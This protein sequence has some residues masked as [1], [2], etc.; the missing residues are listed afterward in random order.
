MKPVAFEY[1][2]PGKISEAAE[3]LARSTGAKILAGGQSLGPLLNLRLAR[4]EV[5][6]DI[7]RIG[8]LR[9]IEETDTVWRVGAGVTH[10]QLEDVGDRLVGAELL[11][12]VARGIAYR[13]VRNRGTIGGSVAHADP[14]AD[15][16]LAL[17]ALAATVVIIERGQSRRRVP[18]ETFMI[19]P[20]TT[21]LKQDDIVVAIEVPKR[22]PGTRYGYFKFCRKVGEF[23]ESSAAAVFDRERG[24]RIFIGCLNGPPQPLPELADAVAARGLSAASDEAC[25][26][27]V[28]EAVP[29][30]DSINRRMHAATVR[31]AIQQAYRA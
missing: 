12:E 10:A 22:E 29:G 30:I 14:A 17:G 4:P 3:T 21:M 5:L 7:S 28:G 23:P 31:R 24:A 16:P 26:S 25:I 20:F 13:S 6:V 27:A 8:E 18:A 19:G 15:W 11:P 2:R 1:Q 9:R